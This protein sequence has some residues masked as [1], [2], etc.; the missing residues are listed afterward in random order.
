M[1]IIPTY[2]IDF[3]VLPISLD[4]KKRKKKIDFSPAIK[5]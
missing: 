2:I 1:K 3:I 4:I 5:Q